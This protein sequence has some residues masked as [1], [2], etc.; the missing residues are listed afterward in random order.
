MNLIKICCITLGIILAG[1]LSMA[2]SIEREVVEVGGGYTT[3][4]NVHLSFSIGEVV[5]KTNRNHN[6]ILTQGFE[7]G[8]ITLVLG[9]DEV[10]N[11]L[12]INAYPNPVIDIINLEMNKRSFIDLSLRVY[13]LQGVLMIKRPIFTDNVQEQINIGQFQPGIYQFALFSSDEKLVESFKILKLK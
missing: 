6:V 12:K 10:G 9:V 5:T 3:T 11:K 13:D 2:Q 1:G 8:R 4:D 7:Q